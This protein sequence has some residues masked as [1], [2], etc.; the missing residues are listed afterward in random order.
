MRMRL[1]LP[2]AICVVGV[3]LSGCSGIL[4]GSDKVKGP[5]GIGTGVDELKES[6]CACTEIPMKFPDFEQM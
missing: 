5:V 6:P 3:G 4:V 2:L 1:M